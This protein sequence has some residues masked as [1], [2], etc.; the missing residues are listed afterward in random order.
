MLAS[1]LSFG[2]TDLISVV[3]LTLKKYS[4]RAVVLQLVQASEA[5]EGFW[6]H[7]SLGPTEFVTQQVWDVIW[8]PTSHSY[9]V[10]SDAYAAGP[11]TTLEE[12][13][14]KIISFSLE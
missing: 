8:K 1:P 14:A 6:K 2:G 4:I 3:E 9:Q 5:P 13:L 10:P 11:G 12:S 7:V